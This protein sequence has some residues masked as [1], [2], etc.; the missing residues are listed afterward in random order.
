MSIDPTL[1][2]LQEKRTVIR[3]SVVSAMRGFHLVQPIVEKKN[4][5]IPRN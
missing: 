3:K 5:D 2:E 1:A 4:A